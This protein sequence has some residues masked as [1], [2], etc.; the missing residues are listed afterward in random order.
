[1]RASLFK[2]LGISNLET[3]AHRKGERDHDQHPREH[4][5]RVAEERA[6]VLVFLRN[7]LKIQN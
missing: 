1:M 3:D 6:Q 7:V 4:D 5:Q 2:Y